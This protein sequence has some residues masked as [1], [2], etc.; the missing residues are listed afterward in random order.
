MGS[1]RR[2]AFP[3]LENSV[4]NTLDPKRVGEVIEA[5]V[6]YLD[7]LTDWE[8]GFITSIADQWERKCWLSEAQLERLE[9]IYVEKVP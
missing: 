8:Q 7:R 5:C 6:D 4:S 2:E 1:Q 9:K 3:R